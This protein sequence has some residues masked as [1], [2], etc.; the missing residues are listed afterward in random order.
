MPTAFKKFFKN[1]RG[2]R[3]TFT[4]VF[5]SFFV[6][7]TVL[8][9]ATMPISVETG[10]I[11]VAHAQDSEDEAEINCGYGFGTGNFSDCI[12]GLV[13]IV[14]YEPAAAFLQ[15]TG[16]G[17][18][19]VVA[20]SLSSELI[21]ES[22]LVNEGWTLT[23]DVV[24]TIFIFVLLYIALSLILQIGATNAKRTLT[25]LIV[26]ALLVNFSL[27]FSRVVIDA[28]NVAAVT[29]YENMAAPKDEAESLV[30]S[31]FA[32][33]ERTL[34]TAVVEGF[35]PQNLTGEESYEAVYD[36]Q[37]VG[38]VLG[39]L[40]IF[41]TAGAVNAIAGIAFF[42][43]AMIFLGRIVALWLLMIFSPLAF[44]G[45]ILPVTQKWAKQW[46]QLLF[47]QAFVAPVFLFFLYLLL[48]FI[49][50]EYIGAQFS[51]P[52]DLFPL[53]TKLI[54][55]AAFYITLLFA[56]VGLTV[57]LSGKAGDTAIKGGTRAG[58]AALGAGGFALRRGGAGAASRAL[59]DSR[60]V[61]GLASRNGATGYVGRKLESGFNKGANSSFDARNTRI[62]S[63]LGATASAAGVR[64]SA[65]K[66]SQASYQKSLNEAGKARQEQ[67]KRIIDPQHQQDYENAR[68]FTPG[69]NLRRFGTG[70]ALARD[71][72]DFNSQIKQASTHEGKVERAFAS[73]DDRM[74][75]QWYHSTDDP[76]E[77]RQIREGGRDLW[78]QRQQE[79]NS[80]RKNN[81]SGAEKKAREERERLEKM[82][83]LG[84]TGEESV[85]S[86]YDQQ[87]QNA[88]SDSE[89][90]QL[91]KE[92]DRRIGE[93]GAEGQLEKDRRE[94]DQ[95][96][97][98]TEPQ[99]TSY[100][101][102][103]SKRQ[104]EYVEAQEKN[105]A[106]KA[107]EQITSRLDNQQKDS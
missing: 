61:Q 86:D 48:S 99:S 73:G 25:A 11:A 71:M 31:N 44:A 15:F 59:R 104:K 107:A 2:V 100:G 80:A 35:D 57:K 91:Q 10:E 76:Y 72:K 106:K 60:A 70:G 1:R 21:G 9:P 18:D 85:R 42:A 78:K 8:M 30:A 93:F 23:R 17:F 89:K 88:E 32:V 66:G 28:S 22:E 54:L 19:A 7:L 63:G 13:Q 96:Q 51:D 56:M 65:G 90:K 47:S 36:E 16:L 81:N 97:G 79:E 24:N 41:L 95:V 26:V 69:G 50:S 29:F 39:F 67:S 3:N 34:S 74:I 43:A 20:F 38:R 103:T 77:R 75:S 83:N 46:L 12:I 55:I 53:L 84:S 27:F 45:F 52:D 58:G 49:G 101:T 33:T 37:G 102:E 14:F 62:A 94:V 87:I 92:R 4:R 105:D 64:G 5:V 82:F 98:G 68:R 6:V 40:L